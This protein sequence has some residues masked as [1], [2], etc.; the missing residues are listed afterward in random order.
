MKR[1]IKNY[2]FVP[3][4]IE[5]D[6]YVLG[7]LL[8]LP[9]IILRED[10]Q[11]GDFLPEYEPQFNDNFDSYGCTV[12][13]TE[14][15]IEILDRFYGKQTNYSERYI[16]ILAGIRPPGASPHDI[17]ETI[18][19]KGLINDA[20]LPF[21]ASFDEFLTPSPMT[22]ELL[23]TGQFWLN[24]N[25]FGHEWVWQS[26][27]NK[28]KRTELMKE[29]LRYSPLGVSVTAWIE[30]NG[31]YVDGGQPN[32]HWCVCFGWGEKGWKIFDSYD[33]SIKILSFDHNIAFCK[34]YGLKE[35]K[36]KQNWLQEILKNLW[37][38][39]LD[40]FV[41]DRLRTLGAQRSPHWNTVRKAFLLRKP[42]CAVCRKRGTLLSPNNVHHCVPFYKNPALELQESNLCTLCR[43]HH[44]FVG[45]LNSWRSWNKDVRIDAEIWYNKI[46][47][48]P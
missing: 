17:A 5:S 22:P 26:P 27:Q 44:F 47:T 32:T 39:F 45:H 25:E 46:K 31:V 3:P 43:E 20:K 6:N 18:R 21:T 23:T 36:K 28:E 12:W 4:K 38:F 16:Y 30:E 10:G 1:N 34:R 2:G 48:R 8:S 9:K 33:Q 37:D 42:E 11:W 41:P 19:K 35:L 40:I 13:G 14:N 24:G 7:G 29:C 15:A